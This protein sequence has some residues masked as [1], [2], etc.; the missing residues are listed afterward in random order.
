[1]LK[2]E[3]IVQIGCLSA[4]QFSMA[5]KVAICVNVAHSINRKIPE[6][7]DVQK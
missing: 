7:N 4:E 1:M 6:K 2:K 5:T 3:S